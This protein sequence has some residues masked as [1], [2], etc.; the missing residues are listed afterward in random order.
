[1]VNELWYP[2]VPGFKYDKALG[3]WSG[4]IPTLKLT[5]GKQYTYRV[6]LADSTS[7]LV[8]FGVR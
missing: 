4:T 3:V 7:F 1:M 6:Q 5:S 2:P 8:T